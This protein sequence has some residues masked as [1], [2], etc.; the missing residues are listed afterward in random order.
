MKAPTPCNP[1]CP[2]SSGFSVF[3]PCTVSTV[4]A[5][6]LS[7]N[8]LQNPHENHAWDM[9]FQLKLTF[10]ASMALAT[11]MNC[12]GD[13]DVSNH[14]LRKMCSEPDLRFDISTPSS[15]ART[16]H[17][18][19]V[20]ARLWSEAESNSCIQFSLAKYTYLLKESSLMDLQTPPQKQNQHFCQHPQIIKQHKVGLMVVKRVTRSESMTQTCSC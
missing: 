13:T 19:L 11:V 15:S 14:R 6:L 10:A 7:N 18:S 3:F 9:K 8:M 17:A 5:C 16:F 2:S 20:S 12:W 1:E 4:K